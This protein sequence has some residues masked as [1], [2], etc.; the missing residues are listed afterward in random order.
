MKKYLAI[1]TE[2]EAMQFLK[3]EIEALGVADPVFENTPNSDHFIALRVLG[4]HEENIFDLYMGHWPDGHTCF[5]DAIGAGKNYTGRGLGS[6]GMKAVL[7]IMHERSAQYLFLRDVCQDGPS[8]WSY[9]GAVPAKE[10][11][12]L[13]ETITMMLEN[14]EITL[15]HGDRDIFERAALVA[16][17][18]P[19]LGWRELSQ[20]DT[21]SDS[22][23]AIRHN[24]FDSFCKTGT[25]PHAFRE[26]MVIFPAEE[27]TRRILEKRLGAIPVFSRQ[28]DAHPIEVMLSSSISQA[29]E[30][31]PTRRSPSHPPSLVACA[32]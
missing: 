20:A 31:L 5:L 12:A 15:E 11:L 17:S 30:A 27:S 26:A 32:T 25:G 23:K 3:G 4:P 21:L 8:F 2:S 14:K 18:C 16:K 6:A 1:S 10:P 28:A 9:Y 19:Y 24:I 7:G 22:G 13:N 29:P